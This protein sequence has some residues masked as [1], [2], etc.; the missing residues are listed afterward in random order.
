MGWDV[1]A[2]LKAAGGGWAGAAGQFGG[3]DASVIRGDSPRWRRAVLLN[4]LASV[5]L[6]AGNRSIGQRRAILEAVQW[7]VAMMSTGPS[8]GDVL[9]SSF[10]LEE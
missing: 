9:Y 3:V 1:A 4:R 7:R 2:L 8:L 10:T 6:V 5:A